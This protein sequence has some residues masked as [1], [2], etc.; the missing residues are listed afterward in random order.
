MLRERRFEWA[1]ATSLRAAV[2]TG[3]S[4][5]ER[6][7]RTRFVVPERGSWC[8]DE[9]RGARTRFVAPGRGSWRPDEVR[10][11]RVRFKARG[12]VYKRC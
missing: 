1:P 5:W 11:A 10:V 7:A 4:T 8:P 9:V 12:P 6:G 2:C 3:Q